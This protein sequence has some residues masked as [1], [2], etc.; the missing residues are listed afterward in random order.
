MAKKKTKQ[1]AGRAARN[2]GASGERE[3]ASFLKDL[4]GV[5]FHRTQQYCGKAGDS[6]VTGEVQG[7]HWESKRTETLSVYKAMQQARDDCK[8]DS[9]PVVCHRRNAKPW[10][11]I[12]ELNELPEL[13]RKLAPFVLE[14]VLATVEAPTDD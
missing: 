7:I 13:V 10:L 11:L 6:D 3:L 1:A 9:L 14:S 4:L 8:D 5:H 12:V 2:K